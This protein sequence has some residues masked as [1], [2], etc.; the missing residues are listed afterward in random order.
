M[1][2]DKPVGS[3]GQHVGT[4]EFMM[5]TH[6]PTGIVVGACTRLYGSQIVTRNVLLEMIE[7]A[8]TNPKFRE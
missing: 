3:G 7:C 5:I 8:I 6:L 1:S 2:F 4:A